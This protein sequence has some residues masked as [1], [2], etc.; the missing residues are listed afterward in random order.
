ML[1]KRCREEIFV[2]SRKAKA[3]GWTQTL[4]LSLTGYL[5]GVFSCHIEA[6]QI[7]GRYDKIE[8]SIDAWQIE[9]DS[10]TILLFLLGCI[11]K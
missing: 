7:E 5:G 8:L 9:L 1:A 4:E 6:G 2:D 3:F 11:K 10:Y